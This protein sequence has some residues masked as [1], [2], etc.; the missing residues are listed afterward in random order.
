MTDAP[1]NILSHI[2]DH[3]KEQFIKQNDVFRRELIIVGRIRRWGHS[4][5][6]ALVIEWDGDVAYRIGIAHVDESTWVRLKNRD[7]KRVILG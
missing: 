2:K 5:L 7:W 4:Q 1:Q 3:N 6:S